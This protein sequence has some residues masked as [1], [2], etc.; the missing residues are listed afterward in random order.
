M[1]MSVPTMILF[2]D[3]KPV[4]QIV[5]AQSK[6]QLLKHLEEHI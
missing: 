3:G 2:K 4:K 1:I 5:G 6:T